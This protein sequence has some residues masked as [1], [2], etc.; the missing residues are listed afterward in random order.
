MTLADKS[1][2]TY[3]KCSDADKSYKLKS[4]I[5]TQSAYETTMPVDALV[6]IV[7]ASAL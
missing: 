4:D 3:T 5:D 7:V 2:I 1:L 6:N